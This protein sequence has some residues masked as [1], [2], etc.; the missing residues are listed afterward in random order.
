MPVSSQCPAKYAKNAPIGLMTPRWIDLEESGFRSSADPNPA[1]FF[2]DAPPAFVRIQLILPENK[3]LN[4]FGRRLQQVAC[5]SMD[6]AQCSQRN[7]Q[8]QMCCDGANFALGEMALSRKHSH[9]TQLRTLNLALLPYKRFRILMI[10]LSEFSD[11]CKNKEKDDFL[12]FP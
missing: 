8:S 1:S 9:K 10:D 7:F 5:K 6:I 12:I 2:P 3:L 4:G 11:R